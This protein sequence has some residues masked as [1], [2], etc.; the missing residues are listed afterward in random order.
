MVK[1]AHEPIRECISCGGKFPKKELIRVV[2][3]ETGIHLDKSGKAMG[4]GAY[5]CQNPDCL[6][7]LKKQKRLN[8]AFREAVSD[9]VYQEINIELSQS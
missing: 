8:R 2:K 3:N 4:R 7:K 6:E 5:L 9:S 1:S